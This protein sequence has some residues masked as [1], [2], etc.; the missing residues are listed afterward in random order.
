MAQL[1]NDCFAFGGPLLSVEAVRALIVERLA[2]VADSAHVPLV[3]ADGC[4]LAERIVAPVDLPPFDNSAVDGYAVRFADLTA[5]AGTVLR[6]AGRVAAGTDPAAS[7]AQRHAVRIFTGA[8]L[9]RGLDTVFMQED[10]SLDGDRVTLPAGLKF[11]AN[12]RLAG[13]DLAQGRVAF[14]AGRRLSPRDV[15]LLA[16]LGLD[17]VPVRRPL[18]VA[19]FSTG[20]EIVAPGEPL[21][22]AALYDANRFMLLAMLRRLGCESSDLGILPD[23]ADAVR[24]ALESASSSHDLLLTSGGVSTGEEDHVKAAVEAAGALTFWRLAIKPGRPV[25]MGVVNA[26]PFIGL[27]GNPV[28][29][30]V[31]FVHVARAVIAR[32]SGETFT[33]PLAFPVRTDFAYRKKEGRREYVR[34]SLRPAPDGGLLAAK[35]PREGAGVITSLTETDGLVELPEPVTRIEPGESVGFL[36]YSSLL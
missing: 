29:V 34:V 20:N 31:T 15:A 27:P 8:P 25:A 6:V 1:S 2:A 35:H 23:R 13:E 14:E 26:K 33:P 5:G 4:V 32:L 30:F 28:A 17:A 21:R 36:P 10:V 18:R 7:Q 19:V 9:P 24:A 22:P 11:G 12:R 16:A 3:A